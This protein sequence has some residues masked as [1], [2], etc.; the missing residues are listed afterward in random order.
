MSNT[1]HAGGGGD[2]S[3]ANDRL[4]TM[5]LVGVL[6]A[7]GCA[8]PTEGGA[9]TAERQAAAPQTTART[10]I[11]PEREPPG[12]PVGHVP[13]GVRMVSLPVGDLPFDCA[14]IR[15]AIKA[16]RL[17]QQWAFDADDEALRML[18]EAPH[19]YIHPDALVE[20]LMP[21]AGHGRPTNATELDEF[22]Q[23][24]R[25]KLCDQLY[26]EIV[27]RQFAAVYPAFR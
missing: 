23:I 24:I 6:F 26:R 12:L 1:K 19:Q 8:S 14:P 9:R 13:N 15:S 25:M 4:R 2:S 21:P 7:T 5:L 10:G 3:S 20:F 18:T 27:N 17:A 11:Q 16:E 22:K